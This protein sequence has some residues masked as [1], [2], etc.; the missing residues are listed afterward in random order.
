MSVSNLLSQEEISCHTMK[1]SKI[2]TQMDK[3]TAEDEMEIAEN[4]PLLQNVYKILRM[5]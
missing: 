2:D 1:H 4:V 5:H 3:Q